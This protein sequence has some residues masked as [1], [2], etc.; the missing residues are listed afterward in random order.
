MSE[1]LANEP[2]GP[3]PDHCAA[4][5]PRGRDAEA[6]LHESVREPEQSEGPAVHLHP[7]VVNPLVFRAFT[8]PLGATESMLLDH[9]R[10][11]QSPAI[12]RR[13]F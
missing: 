8:D 3:I 13:L 4:K 5:L 7:A 12:S 6:P 11:R 2:L 1:H 9:V 10:R